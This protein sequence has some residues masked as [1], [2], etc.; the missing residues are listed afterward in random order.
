M[1]FWDSSA[2]VPLLVR[3]SRTAALTALQSE[4]SDCAVWWGSVVE[5]AAAL[6]RRRWEG[7]IS[8]DTEVAAR[9]RLAELTGAWFE[10]SPSLALRQ[11]A[12]RLVGVHERLRAGDALQLAA[13]LVWAAGA[14]PAHTVVTLDERL[15]NAALREGFL[16]LP[17]VL[18]GEAPAAPEST[19]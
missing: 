18:Q 1:K 10:I 13:A 15:R 3:E 11:R 17:E 12:E 16:V 8:G 6:A 5:C 9:R 14:S 7:T 4:D 19:P 2:I